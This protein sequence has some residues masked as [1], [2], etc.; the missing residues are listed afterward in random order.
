MTRLQFVADTAQ[1]AT[2]AI[3]AALGV[4]VA[5]IDDQ[6]QLVATSKTFLNKRGTDI[7]KSFVQKVN[8][9]G[10]S[11]IPNP[12]HHEFCKGCKYENNC[13]ETA[14]VI[15][16]MKYDGE[17]I[18]VILMVTYTQAQKERILANTEVLLEFI[19]EMADLICKDIK[20]GEAMAN[21]KLVTKQLQTT[22]DF[23]DDG[24][25]M[26]DRYGTIT[27]SNKTAQK[28]ADINQKDWI[29]HSIREFLPFQ[30][31]DFL[32]NQGRSLKRLE[33]SAQNPEKGKFLVS[34]D[35]II[36]KEKVAGAVMHI[37]DMDQVHNQVY[38]YSQTQIRYSFDDI[39]GDSP[40][41]RA[42]VNYASQISANDST[43]LIQG[44][45]GTG[46]ELFA[47]AIHNHSPRRNAPFIPINCAAIPEAL[48]ESELFGYT[49]GAFTGAKKGGKPGKFEMAGK[50]TI[51]LDEIGDMP[52]HMQAK[53][54]RVLQEKIVERVGSVKPIPVKARVI[55][56]TNQ[57]LESREYLHKFRRDLFFRLSVMPLTI[58]PLRERK[59][60]IL[61]L[62]E[63]FMKKYAARF[64]SQVKGLDQKAR[65]Q[66]LIHP[67]PGN[68]RELE[69]AIE[70]AVNM[71]RSEK[72]T[73]ACLPANVCQ[74][75]QLPPKEQGL[76]ARIKEYE[77]LI[78]VQS[79][80]LHGS[81]VPGKKEVARE[82]GISLPTLYRRI[83]ELG[84]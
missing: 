12:G 28:M 3:A 17:I 16:T 37:E 31:Y 4:D 1:H 78:I 43:I 71:E 59:S 29:N 44:E 82:L 47:R 2:Q 58:P 56:A 50:G 41:I 21:E 38:E 61:V 10:S 22:M 33:V 72:I 9:T 63:Y 73:K 84:I 20:L 34:A 23:L 24:I 62:A 83:K 40:E 13:P 67:W 25:I 15:R 45:S 55:A 66:L 11:V 57:N 48:L 51:F 36:V 32:I 18:G 74:S 52:L 46:K 39:K 30:V 79:L 8:E 53:L 35:P 80:E 60:D 19:G 81:S 14:E 69:N 68:V 54:L 27:Q 26:V 75:I 5:M 77:R 7:N 49:D 64:H 65:E 70:Y 42:V 76:T 6:F